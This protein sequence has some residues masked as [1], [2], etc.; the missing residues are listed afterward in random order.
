MSE[1]LHKNNIKTSEKYSSTLISGNGEKPIRN[2]IGNIKDMVKKRVSYA[3]AVR[4]TPGQEI[5]RGG[6]R[7]NYVEPE[8]QAL[9]NL[10]GV[11]STELTKI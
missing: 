5:V 8:S 9:S 3:D 7:L 1:N 10:S 2:E 6:L 4:T 11:S